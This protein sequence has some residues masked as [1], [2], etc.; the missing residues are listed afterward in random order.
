MNSTKK[1]NWKGGSSNYSNALCS[2]IN[3]S[4]RN[5][6]VEGIEGIWC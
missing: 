1:R 6:D 5:T 3:G 2:K 4:F